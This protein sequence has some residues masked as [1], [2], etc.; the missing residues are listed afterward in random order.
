MLLAR[1][2]LSRVTRLSQRFGGC[3]TVVTIIRFRVFERSLPRHME[4]SPSLGDAR[5]WYEAGASY[6]FGAGQVQKFSNSGAVRW[7]EEALGILGG[8]INTYSNGNALLTL[9]WTH[10][11]LRVTAYP[12][13]AETL[14]T[15]E[16][17]R[18]PTSEPIDRQAACVE[19]VRE[20][21]EQADGSR[22]VPS[23]NG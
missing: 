21:T 10:S 12:A 8:T 14:K 2:I 16:L 5:A 7:E 13:M 18:A 4:L 15:M 23:K 19:E 3:S 1:P 20:W 11:K 9:R 22:D 6:K 17:P